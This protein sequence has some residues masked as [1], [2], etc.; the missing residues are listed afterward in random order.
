MVLTDDNFA[1]IVGAVEEGRTIY[2]NIVKFVRFQ[3][4]T[5][6]GAVLSVFAAPLVGLPV[7]FDPIQLL[8]VNIIMDG[9][10]AMALGVDRGRPEVMDAQPHRGDAPILSLQRLL[11][12]VGLG[13]IMATGTLGVLWYGLETR[14]PEHARTLAFTTFVAFQFFNAFNV[15]SETGT[16]FEWYSFSNGSLWLALAAVLV[17]QVLATNWKPV[18]EIFDTVELDA[19]DAVLAIAVASS[20]VFVEEAG[21]AL[22]RHFQRR[23]GTLRTRSAAT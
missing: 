16:G 1:T 5:N 13:L 2:D 10:P 4:S 21:K 6:F 22:T 18:Q 7:P 23:R 14:A 17:L 11:R 15:R 9:P 8:W 19:G 20:I 3:L 12:L